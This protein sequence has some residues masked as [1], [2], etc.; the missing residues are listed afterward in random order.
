MGLPSLSSFAF[1]GGNSQDILAPSR[2]RKASKGRPFFEM[3]PTMRS[4]LPSLNILIA[5]SGG[6]A[7][8]HMMRPTRKVCSQVPS[9]FFS[10]T[11]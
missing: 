11:M 10:R 9:A 7:F 5:C 3:K 4:V 1:R 6:M 8:W 2:L